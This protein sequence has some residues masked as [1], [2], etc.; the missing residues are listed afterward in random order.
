MMSPVG[1]WMKRIPASNM[2]T[3]MGRNSLPVFCWGSLLSMTGAV[4]R[5]EAGGGWAIDTVLVATGLFLLALLARVLDWRKGAL[6][7]A[8]DFAY[9]PGTPIPKAA[10]HAPVHL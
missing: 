9:V 1:E 6:R 8:D 7:S 10:V 2:F 3:S 5:H 4:I